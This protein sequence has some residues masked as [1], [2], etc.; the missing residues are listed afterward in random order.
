MAEAKSLSRAHLSL[1][2]L[3]LSVDFRGSAKEGLLGFARSPKIL[4]S[5]FTG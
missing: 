5:D 3:F 4:T 1:Q 2:P